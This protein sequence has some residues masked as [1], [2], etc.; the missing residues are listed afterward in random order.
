MSS[1][2]CLSITYSFAFISGKS[3]CRAN[4]PKLK[5]R[6]PS[7]G[8]KVR[9]K[10][11]NSVMCESRGLCGNQGGSFQELSF[12][13]FA[14]VEKCARG[15]VRRLNERAVLLISQLD[16]ASHVTQKSSSRINHE[17]PGKRRRVNL[18][19]QRLHAWPARGKRRSLIRQANFFCA[20]REIF[21]SLSVG[22]RGW[23]VVSKCGVGLWCKY[24]HKLTI[25]KLLI[26]L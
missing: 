8:A 12:V 13:C 7:H 20:E 2:H 16:G 15:G 18:L 14:R 10:V 6:G 24:E 4:T 3:F 5:A 25:K 21:K 22:G 9:S 11:P 1:S 23:Q 17:L 19:P 26:F